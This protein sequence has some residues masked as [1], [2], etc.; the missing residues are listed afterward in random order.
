MKWIPSLAVFLCISSISLGDYRL[1]ENAPKYA[2]KMF[3]K[4]MEKRESDRTNAALELGNAKSLLDGYK[5][6]I[7]APTL[8]RNESP[9]LT[10]KGVWAFK[11]REEKADAIQLQSRVV[12][13]SESQ[14]VK[15]NQ[16]DYMPLFQPIWF[17]LQTSV[18]SEYA[19][20]STD[21]QILRAMENNNI[22]IDFSDGW[23]GWIPFARVDFVEKEYSSITVYGRVEIYQKGLGDKP[24]R[25]I[26]ADVRSAYIPSSFVGNAANGDAISLG[27][28]MFSAKVV[29]GKFYLSEIS[30]AQW[31]EYIPPPSP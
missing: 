20:E 18:V 17:A 22:Q 12:E 29:Q 31:M 27:N 7:I 10:N 9:R 3:A 11:T 8:R 15:L 23:F 16:D 2:E 4:I 21:D 13:E 25:T 26:L 24:I 14:L 5:K 30:L 6:A 28:A 1:K 19:L